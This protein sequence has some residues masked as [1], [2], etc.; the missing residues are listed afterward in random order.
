M[1]RGRGGRGFTGEYQRGKK[2]E[3]NQE[4]L[5]HEVTV[6]NSEF[7]RAEKTG[8]AAFKYRIS[9]EGTKA[10]LSFFL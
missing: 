5:E 2:K 6:E 8:W 7:L 10:Y 4:R 1:A 3:R 9:G